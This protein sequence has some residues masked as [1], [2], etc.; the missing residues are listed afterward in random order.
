MNVQLNLSLSSFVLCTATFM[1]CL[2]CFLFS[3]LNGLQPGMLGTRNKPTQRGCSLTS[4]NLT[5]ST[6]YLLVQHLPDLEPFLLGNWATWG[7]SLAR[8]LCTS[9][10]L[11]LS[12]IIKLSVAFVLQTCIHPICEGGGEPSDHSF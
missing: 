11:P 10:L 7:Q 5:G 12:Y 3:I 8:C 1:A 6:T 9:Y 2:L 4:Q